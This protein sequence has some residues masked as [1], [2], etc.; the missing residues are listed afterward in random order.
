M[1]FKNFCF[2]PPNYL[3]HTEKRSHEFFQIK[4]IT[5]RRFSRPLT[6]EI[7]YFIT[8]S[9][10]YGLFYKITVCIQILYLKKTSILSTVYSAICSPGTAKSCTWRDGFPVLK[11]LELPWSSIFRMLVD[12]FYKFVNDFVKNVNSHSIMSE[13]ICYYHVT[14]MRYRPISLKIYYDWS[15]GSRVVIPVR[16]GCSIINY[17]S[18]M[19]REI[20][21]IA[22]NSSSCRLCQFLVQ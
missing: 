1:F 6:S 5:F 16:S 20:I 17:K 14:F 19:F 15:Y 18:T 8:I 22:R 4:K 9:S 3:Y 12:R 11:I 21:Q 10:V 7:I 13:T 2:A